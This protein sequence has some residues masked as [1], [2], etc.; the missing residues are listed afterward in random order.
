LRTTG[1]SSHIFNP[2]AQPSKRHALW[3]N[4]RPCCSEQQPY[5]AKPAY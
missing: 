1:I 3:Q 4:D 5:P 2:T